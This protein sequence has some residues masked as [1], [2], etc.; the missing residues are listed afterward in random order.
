MKTLINVRPEMVAVL[1]PRLAWFLG[2]MLLAGVSG[3]GPAVSDQAS[4]QEPRASLSAQPESQP[5]LQHTPSLRIG[6]STPVASPMAPAALAAANHKP[7]SAAQEEPPPL[8]EHLV[9]PAWIAQALE[10]PDVSVR[11]LAL[12]VWAQ[13]GVEAPLDPLV[14]ALDDEDDVV[15]TKAMMIIE[16][17]WTIEQEAEQEAEK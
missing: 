3:C 5:V 11:L 14:V 7:A 4:N 15:R 9:M 17:N 12:D 2:L 1:C 10:T 8:P 6:P 13:Q 16:R